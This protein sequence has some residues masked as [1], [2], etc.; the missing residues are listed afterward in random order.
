VACL[1]IK[2][3]VGTEESYGIDLSRYIAVP[4]TR[5]QVSPD[6]TWF[7]IPALPEPGPEAT[8]E[9]VAAYQAARKVHV[10]RRGGKG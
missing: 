8:E 5:F 4:G 3:I 1:R 9:E 7:E 10:S 2:P 6:P